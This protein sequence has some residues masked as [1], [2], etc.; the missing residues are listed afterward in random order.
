MNKLK[1]G[2]Q[3]IAELILTNAQFKNILF[4]LYRHTKYSK[5]PEVARV[6]FSRADVSGEQALKNL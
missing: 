5:D 4:N 6:V 2:S 1:M 3:I